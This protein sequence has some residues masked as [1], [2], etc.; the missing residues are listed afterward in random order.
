MLKQ[1]QKIDNFIEQIDLW[2]LILVIWI[3][4]CLY[5]KFDYLNIIRLA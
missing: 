2:L 3:L 5:I 4:I 1:I